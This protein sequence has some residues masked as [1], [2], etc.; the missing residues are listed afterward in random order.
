MS[1]AVATSS[2]RAPL[3][4]GI[5]SRAVL[6]WL[7]HFVEM[8]IAMIVGMAVLGMQV[9]AIAAA[10]G[11]RDLHRNLPELAT[12]LMVVEMALPMALWMRYRGHG[13]RGVL[14]M[15]SAMSLPAVALVGAGALGFIDR[16]AVMS[17]YHPAMYAAMVGLMV[18][19]R[20][21]FAARTH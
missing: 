10:M 20:R 4:R 7:G 15:T 2:R 18:Y 9:E 12:I 3:V 11:Q 16:S 17:I 6:A 13:R 8:V 19:R 14:E 1:Q 21:E 5:R